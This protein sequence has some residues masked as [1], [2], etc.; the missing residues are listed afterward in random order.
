MHKLNT[1]YITGRCGVVVVKKHIFVSTSAAVLL[2]STKPFFLD[3]GTWGP[4]NCVVST[5]TIA[6]GKI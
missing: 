2:I 4:V 1:K 6:I 3:M 5:T